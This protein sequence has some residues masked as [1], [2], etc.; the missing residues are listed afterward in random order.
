MANDWYVSP[1]RR[2][3]PHRTETSGQEKK[4]VDEEQVGQLEP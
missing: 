4:T 1:V 3:E 2:G